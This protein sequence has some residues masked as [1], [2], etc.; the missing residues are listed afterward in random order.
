MIKF[1]A[2]TTIILSGTTSC[3]KTTWLKRLLNDN[4]FDISP[5]RIVYCYG[6]WQKIFNHMK[7]VEFFEGL[8][9]AFEQFADDKHN[10]I[11]IDD[12]QDEVCKSKAVE[13]LFTRESHHKNLSVIYITQNIFYQGKHSRTIALNTHVTVLFRNPRAASQIKILKSQTGIKRLYEAYE[14]ATK[15]DYGYLV[16]DLSPASD[17]EYSLRTCVFSD[18]DTIIYH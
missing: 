3:G 14:D 1:S 17:R 18:E 5:K 9:D 10:L 15:N 4:L 11:I 2:P 8:P 7:G 12:L 6:V 13:N 16:V